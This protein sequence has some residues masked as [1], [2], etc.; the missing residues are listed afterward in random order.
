MSTWER[1]AECGEDEDDIEYLC[2]V[3]DYYRDN[4]APAPDGFLLVECGATPRHWPIYELDVSKDFWPMPCHYCVSEQKQEEIYRLERRLHW[5]DH[6][7]FL[8]GK[9]AR[10]VVGWAYRMGIIAGSGTHGGGP[11]GCVGCR[12]VRFKGRRPYILGRER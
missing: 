10:K 4:P 12:T 8:R 11:N 6:P 9:L 5:I 1:P 2:R 3:A 7:F